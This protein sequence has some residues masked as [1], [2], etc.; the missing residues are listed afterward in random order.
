MIIYL[1]ILSIILLD[2]H[3]EH[4]LNKRELLN[5]NSLLSKFL[6]FVFKYRILTILTLVFF[7]T[8]RSLSVGSDILSYNKHFISLK[9]AKNTLSPFE[10]G[11]NTLCYIIGPV[12]NLNIRSLFFVISLF[13]SISFVLFINKFSCNKQ[14]SLLLYVMFGIFAQS[15]SAL[16]QII[17]ID[18]ALLSLIFI[19][20]KKLFRGIILI[21]FASFFH[22]S[23]LLCLIYIPLRYL[24]LTNIY[25][26]L[27]T[28]CTII[29]GTTLPL[30]L[31]F[32]ESIIPSLNYYSSYFTEPTYSTF[33]EH[34]LFNTLYTI[35]MVLIFLILYL[36]RYK[37]FKN[38][39]NKDSYFNYF[40]SLFLIVPLIRIVGFILGL[41]SLLNRINMYFFFLLIIL[42]PRF[43]KCFKS[44]KFN[45]LLY[46]LTY[47]G[48]FAYMLLNYLLH[49]SC[50][51]VPYI[52]WF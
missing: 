20:D 23:A 16:R 25:I 22:I 7:S 19:S 9:T 49:D 29:L 32:I 11:Y 46:S 35:G 27:I 24:K 17:A 8:F 39:L 14:M 3:I 31:Q 51:V 45:N 42:V 30:L 4:I 6:S 2:F 52:F 10:W 38:E 18:F 36:A 33:H 28:I 5:K 43:L 37:W 48:A 13:T 26:I 21:L 1:L 44:Y 12:L 34:T 40:L 15:L 47:I 41:E 50:G